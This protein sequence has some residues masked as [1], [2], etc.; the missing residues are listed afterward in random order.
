MIDPFDDYIDG[1]DMS[2]LPS[3]RVTV[4]PVYLQPR[5]NRR[6]VIGM[7]LGWLV[8]VLVRKLIEHIVREWN[9]GHE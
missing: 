5:I 8:G 9:D 4:Y 1:M 6:V 7:E 2:A 3:V